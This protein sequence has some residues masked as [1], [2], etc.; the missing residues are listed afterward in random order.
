MSEQLLTLL[1]FSLLALLYLFL[2]RVVRAVWAELSPPALDGVSTTRSRK[3]RGAPAASAAAAPGPAPVGAGGA[4][5]ATAPA[6]TGRRS[7]KQAKAAKGTTLVIVA[8]PEAAGRSF[9][10][11]DETTIGR[12]PGCAVAIDDTFASQ[13]HARV[14][15]AD[16]T[17]HV[18]DLGSTNGTFLGDEAVG[19]PRPLRRGDQLRIGSTVLE[20]R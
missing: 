15:R 3:R 7:R 9:T 1:K 14:F 6:A 5:V 11:G 16:G 4:A 2:F 17:L 18:E 10:L 8:P 19:G 13:L 20:L 12:S